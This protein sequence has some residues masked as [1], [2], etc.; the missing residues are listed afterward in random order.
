MARTCIYRRGRPAHGKAKADP[1]FGTVEDIQ[2]GDGVTYYRGG[3]NRTAAVV[4]VSVPAHR[5]R[6]EALMHGKAILRPSVTLSF[7][8]VLEVHRKVE[9]APPEGTTT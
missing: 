3:R 6:T 1:G 5:L 7:D 8:E 2:V 9:D 4:K